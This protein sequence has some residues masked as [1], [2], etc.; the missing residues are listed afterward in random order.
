MG[1][2][3]DE[4]IELLANKHRRNEAILALVGA[5]NGSDLRKVEL[6]AE[7]RAAL[8]AGLR[9]ENALVRWWC[10]QLID[11]LADGRDFRARVAMA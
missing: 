1:T 11:H 8:I 9:H 4:L 2:R 7:A 3:H 6:T 5:I 10:L